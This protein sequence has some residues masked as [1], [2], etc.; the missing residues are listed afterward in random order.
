MGAA[1]YDGVP[2]PTSRPASTR[3]SPSVGKGTRPVIVVTGSKQKGDIYTEAQAGARYLEA[4]GVPAHDIVQAGGNDC[5]SNLAD[6]AAQLKARGVHSVLIVTDKFHEDRSM[7][8]ASLGRL[9]AVSRRRPTRRPSP[10]SP[11]CRTSS[12]RRLGVAWAGSSA[13]RT[14][15]A[16]G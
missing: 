9:P 13:S 15:T 4:H 7:A 2:S 11:P 16:L 1:Q 8:I 5:W 14:S 6:A 10:G 3:P 12:R